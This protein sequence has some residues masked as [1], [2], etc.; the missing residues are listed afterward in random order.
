MKCISK[1]VLG[2]KETKQ[3]Y[4]QATY[5][6]TRVIEKLWGEKDSAHEERRE[7]SRLNIT[8]KRQDLEYGPGWTGSI[9]SV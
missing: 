1:R 8:I 4:R 7:G 9:G 5:T 2:D 6:R 3:P